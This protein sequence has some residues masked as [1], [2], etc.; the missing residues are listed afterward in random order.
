MIRRGAGSARLQSLVVL[1]IRIGG[2]AAQMALV[3][4]VALQFTV[5]HVGLNG[6]LW[7]TALVA[8]MAGTFG[9]DI[10]GMREQAPLWESN[11][12]RRARLLARR[13]ARTVARIWATVGAVVVIVAGVATWWGQPGWMLVAFWVVGAS[14][15]FARL[16]MVQRM[17]RQMPVAGQFLESIALPVLGLI[18]ALVAAAFAPQLLI[19]GQA[20]AFVVVALSMWWISPTPG[21]RLAH[22]R[23]HGVEIPPTP[24]RVAL[25]LGFGATLT[26]LCVR[27]P[28]FILSSRSLAAAGTYD[29]AQRIQSAGAMGT[30]AVTTVFGPRI[31][32][33]LRE[34]TVLRK[35][36]VEAAGVS[37]VLPVI[38]LG[39]L[40]VIGEDALVGLLGQEYQGTWAASV[41]LVGATLM[42]ALTS[43]T[44]NVLMLGGYERWF[45]RISAVQLV[46]VVGGA[47]VTGADSAL[48]VAWWVLGSEAFRSTAMVTGYV[49][50]TRSLT[51]QQ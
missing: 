34:R 42:N 39:F 46:V 35:L 28:M 30:S 14:S 37:V 26:A 24:W 16:F 29:V 44:S 11:S 23:A 40:L 4:V 1:S 48:A 51:Q 38:L 36:M 50:H 9:L 27:G 18:A 13:D 7:S 20:A 49:L 32:V 31:A 19:A 47:W 6:L 3:A 8:R 43:A 12:R 15:A 33:A 25:P 17:A 10:S 22:Y 41:V 21:R 5:E 45:M 2:A